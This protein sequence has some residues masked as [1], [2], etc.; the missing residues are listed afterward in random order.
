MWNGFLFLPLHTSEILLWARRAKKCIKKPGNRQNVLLRNLQ[1]VRIS[2]SI[3]FIWDFIDWRLIVLRLARTLCLMY[4]FRSVVDSVKN[5][6]YKW[7]LHTSVVH[8]S[9]GQVKLL[10]TKYVLLGSHMSYFNL[11]ML[12]MPIPW[13]FLSYTFLKLCFNKQLGIGLGLGYIHLSY[14][15]C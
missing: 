11:F 1:L 5:S 2:T 7:L 3:Q 15:A 12:V 4:I 10:N 13:Q 8:T 9:S 14:Y 6:T